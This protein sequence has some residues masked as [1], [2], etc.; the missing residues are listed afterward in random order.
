MNTQ[1]ILRFYGS[2]LDFKLDSSEFYDFELTK[3]DYDNAISDVISNYEPLLESTFTN[4]IDVPYQ[5]EISQDNLINRRTE[6]G[7]TTN[8]VFNRDNLPWSSGSVFYYWGITNEVVD[9]NYLDNNLS[10]Q[11]TEN[12]EI[13]WVAVHYS[14]DC[15][16]ISGYMSSSYI[17]TGK[18]DTLCSDGTSN[19]FNLTITFER[20]YNLTGCDIENEGGWNDLIQGPHAIPYTDQVWEPTGDTVGFLSGAFLGHADQIVTGYTMTTGSFDWVTGA[21]EYTYV[22]ELNKKWSNERDKRLGTLKIY[23]NGERIYKL[24]DWEEIVP[25]LRNSENNIIQS[26]GGGT[27]GSLD[28]HI[29][30]TQFSLKKIEYFDFPLDFTHV[31]N[32]YRTEIKPNF[33][34]IECNALCSDSPIGFVKPSPT[35]TPTPSNTPTPTP[36]PTPVPINNNIVIDANF[37]PGSTI[38]LYTATSDIPVLTNTTIAFDN[39]IELYDGTSIL[40]RVSIT[41]LEGETVGTYEKILRIAYNDVNPNICEFTNFA[42]DNNVLINPPQLNTFVFENVI[43]E[44]EVIYDAIITDDDLIYH[45]NQLYISA[46][47]NIYI[48]FVEPPS[49]TPNPTPTPSSTPIPTPSVTPSVTPSGTPIPTPTPTPT[50]SS[51]P[52]VV[53][54]TFTFNSINANTTINSAIKTSGGGWDSSA[55]SVETYINPVSVTF[56][57]SNTNIGTMGGFSVN[58]TLYGSTYQNATFGL[59]CENG[60]LKIYENGNNVYTVFDGGTITPSD[61]FMV[62]YDGTNVKYYFNGSLVYT[63]LQSITQPLYVFFPL[64]TANEG[65]TNVCVKE[66]P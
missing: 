49:T 46:G 41:I 5:I 55:Y 8:F 21:T 29:G 58:P 36:T 2:K 40:I 30:D 7:W 54:D 20:N 9:T 56:N 16:P 64:L 61:L 47:D 62:D 60:N 12:G 25:S 6:K 59:Y 31:R 22:E 42:S 17:A 66:T 37:S 51:S 32:Y 23:L 10:F 26:W 14:G 53:C 18:T 28:L 3:D 34:I 52:S 1:N 39:I 38:I 33:S 65:V 35:P 15:N 50:P 24:M 44:E 45:D 48:R 27:S 19:D 4:N 43:P 11:F 13:E 63:S 57:L